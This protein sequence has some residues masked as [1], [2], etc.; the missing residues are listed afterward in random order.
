MPLKPSTPSKPAAPA[1]NVGGAAKAFNDLKSLVDTLVE[2]LEAVEAKMAEYDSNFTEIQEALS[3]PPADGGSDETAGAGAEG[4]AGDEGA[5]DE[6]PTVEEIEA[7]DDAT[8]KEWRKKFFD[9]SEAKTKPEK[10]R[11]MLLEAVQGGAGDEGAGDG[12]DA[13][14]DEGAAAE[15]DSASGNNHFGFVRGED[16]F[17]VDH[18]ELPYWKCKTDEQK[19]V[20]LA[21][22]YQCYFTEAECACAKG[23]SE[24]INNCF[25]QMLDDP[26][27]KEMIAKEK[28][29]M[30]KPAA[31]KPAPLW[32][33]S[34]GPCLPAR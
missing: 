29:L 17:V 26:A 3:A 10:I 21:N 32:V 20:K 33:C 14:A 16:G 13:A 7:A 18:E 2:R 34:H 23:D 11:E 31:G 25:K 30:P 12:A 22:V 15:G 24:S 6:L 8:L 1:A 28:A 9:P 27:N 5:G 19:A 4:G